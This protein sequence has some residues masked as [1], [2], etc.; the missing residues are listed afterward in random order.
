MG[1]RTLVPQFAP[2]ATEVTK[3]YAI[4]GSTEELQALVQELKAAG[5]F[6]LKV[7][8]DGTA[9]VRAT[10]VGIAVSTGKAMARYIPLG[11][12]GF[13]GG[14]SMA[15]SEALELLAPLLTDPA[16]EKIGHDLK[17][18]L[19]VLGRH[20]VDVSNPNGFDTM[21]AS[22]LVDANRSSQD[23]EPIALEQDRKSVV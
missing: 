22:Y 5:R 6:S 20:G 4:V 10:L 23:L 17:A 8:T 13:G 18:D 14:F 9:P 21:L 3:D 11:H 12:E 16:I 1:F 2:T 15:K 19:I 7:I